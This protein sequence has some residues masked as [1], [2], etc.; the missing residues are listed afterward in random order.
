MDKELLFYEMAK[1]HKTVDEVCNE[2]G[3]SKS[4]FYRKLSGKSQFTLNEIKCI[5]KVLQLKSPMAIFFAEEV[6]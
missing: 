1:K 3:V 5:V 6:S 2:I 4:A